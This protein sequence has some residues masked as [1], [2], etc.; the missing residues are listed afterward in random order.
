[1]GLIER[2]HNNERSIWATIFPCRGHPGGSHRTYLGDSRNSGGRGGRLG[3]GAFDG[4]LDV[5]LVG[6][7][8][9]DGRSTV[10][11]S[12]RNVARPFVVAQARNEC[13]ST[14]TMFFRPQAVFLRKW[15]TRR[16]MSS[17]PR[18]GPGTRMGITLRR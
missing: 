8:E 17:R 5:E 13:G 15:L 2:S 11:S 9:R 18:A 14:R 12:W 6:G 3:L 10:F 16:G 4:Q 1:M 7:F